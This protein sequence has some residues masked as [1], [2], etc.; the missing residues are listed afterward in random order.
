MDLKTIFDNPIVKTLLIK[1]LKAAWR[2]NNIRLITITERDGELE[3]EVF[4]EP[5]K[6]LSQKDFINI[7]Q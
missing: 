1:K 4:T 7:I 3:F 2:E 5:M 6:V